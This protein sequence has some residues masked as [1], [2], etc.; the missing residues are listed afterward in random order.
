M[1]LLDQH[2]VG[3]SLSRFWPVPTRTLLLATNSVTPSSR[4][5]LVRA[6]LK[7]TT[8]K[9]EHYLASEAW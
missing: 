5:E 8:R 2:V 1:L 4:T 6:M 3:A 7:V 9:E